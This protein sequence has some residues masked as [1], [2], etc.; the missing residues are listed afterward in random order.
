MRVFRKLYNYFFYCGIDKEEYRAVK[1][2]VY[3]SNFVIWRILHILMAATLAFL[4]ITS[5]FNEL[6]SKN[7]N[8]Y[9]IGLIYSLAATGLF[10]ILKKDSIIAQFLIYIT[11]T[12]LFL[13][14][15]FISMNNSV[16]PATTFIV[17]LLITPMFMI[18]KPVFMTVELCVVS[19]LFLTLMYGIKS[20]DIWMIDL[21]NVV[22]FTMI[23]VFLNI[24]SNAVRIRTYV[25]TRELNIQKDFDE[26]TGL[27]NKSAL[28]REINEYLADDTRNKGIM[29]MLDIDSFKGINDTYGHDTGDRVISQLGAILG[30]HFTSGEITG[31]FGGDE[32]IVFIKDRDDIDLA[33]S[34]A[35]EIVQL[36]SEGITL[37]ET[38]K[39]VSVSI[40]IALYQGIEKNYSEIFKKADI[41]L[42]KTKAEPD[43]RFCVYQ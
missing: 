3:I 39:K 34:T 43:K 40:G 4:Y 27:K 42:Y 28:T 25:L 15:C 8:V 32:F 10:F 7:S 38:D 41:A 20:P 19:A 6:L 33:E 11:I 16:V 26:L 23:A 12:L 13:F 24:I 9:L 30:S 14:A 18:D 22:T 21:V 17:F 29:F 35:R 5:L 31:R 1:K 36:A 37:P 2:E